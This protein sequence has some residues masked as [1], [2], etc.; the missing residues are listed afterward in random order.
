MKILLLFLLMCT[1]SF[2]IPIEGILWGMSKEQLN[3]KYS[4]LKRVSFN[5]R[6]EVYR[7]EELFKS[8]TVI[9]NFILLDGK[10]IQMKLINKYPRQNATF[11][12]SLMD[13]IDDTY[14]FTSVETKYIKKD[15]RIKQVKEY[16]GISNDNLSHIIINVDIVEGKHINTFIFTD[17]DF[18]RD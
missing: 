15:N 14:T 3:N 4:N 13:I 10:L 5:K 8:D 6:E 7:A 2:G 9:L 16:S 12:K 11:S 1:M 17:Q 18:Y